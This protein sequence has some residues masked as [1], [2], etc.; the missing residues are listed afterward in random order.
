[1]NSSTIFL[2]LLCVTVLAVVGVIIDTNYNTVIE[3]QCAP[4][5]LQPE[6]TD[7]SEIRTGRI[8]GLS[9]S[10]LVSIQRTR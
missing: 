8:T 2:A 3:V 6:L 9:T 5:A 4:L 1:M 7:C 10:K